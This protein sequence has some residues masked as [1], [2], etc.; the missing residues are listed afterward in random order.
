MRARQFPPMDIKKF[1]A[2]ACAALTLTGWEASRQ[3]AE[4]N[5][6]LALISARLQQI[7]MIDGGMLQMKELT[8][9]VGYPSMLLTSKA[10]SKDGARNVDAGRSTRTTAW[11]DTKA[12]QPARLQQQVGPGLR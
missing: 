6:Q 2:V 4:Q 9:S 12:G 1:L 7:V 3:L 5:K 8:T 11:G 10:N